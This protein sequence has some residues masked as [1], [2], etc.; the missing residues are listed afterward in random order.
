MGQGYLFAQLL[1][2]QYRLVTLEVQTSQTTACS[3]SNAVHW[4][5][6]CDKLLIRPQLSPS[7]LSQLP[8]TVTRGV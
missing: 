5:Y 8:L 2:L 3:V 7:C 6:L 1:F 4:H